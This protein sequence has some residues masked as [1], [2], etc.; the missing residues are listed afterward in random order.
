MT[1]I[2]CS[3]EVRAEIFSVGKS[4][5]GVVVVQQGVEQAAPRSLLVSKPGAFKPSPPVR[6]ITGAGMQMQAQPQMR[7]STKQRYRDGD[8]SK[9]EKY[10][11]QPERQ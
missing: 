10:A 9:V 6:V 2:E 8:V 7:L 3:L 11:P 4:R 1:E 5:D